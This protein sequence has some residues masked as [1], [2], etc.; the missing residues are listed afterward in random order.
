MRRSALALAV[1]GLAAGCMTGPDYQRPEIALPAAHRSTGAVAPEAVTGSERATGG[2]RAL[3]ALPPPATGGAELLDAAWWS[4]LGDPHLD[5]LIQAALAENK[6]LRAAAARI[7]QF[8]AYLQVSKSAG[9]P[10]AGYRAAR[11][12][13]T[14]SE[15]RQ[16]PLVVGADPVANN[17]EFSF[18]ASWELD[19]W[20]KLRRADEAAYANLVASEEARRA[21]ALSLVSELTAGYIRLLSLDREL[22]LL[23][24]TILS[25]RASLKLAEDRFA[26]GGSGELPVVQAQI[27]LQERES[28]VPEKLAQIAALENRLSQLAGRNPGP[29]ARAGNL[30]EL[31]P[32]K[33]PAGLPADVLVQRPDVRRAE[34]E[35][36]AANAKIG[37]AKAQ[38]LPT[39]ALTG[40][41]GQASTQLSTLMLLTSNFGSFGVA[42]L[43]PLFTAGRIEGQV[44]EAEALREQASIAFAASVQTALRE[45]D[46]ALT[47]HARAREQVALRTLQVAT[48]REQQRLALGRFEG[49]LSGYF[50]VLE[51][52]R[53]LN[54]GLQWL[55]Q[56]RREALTTLIAAYKATGGGWALPD[57]VAS[58]PTPPKPTE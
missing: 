9:L 8:A 1:V 56:A 45:V 32:P 5:A 41:T 19:L 3:A 55:N 26:G 53:G 35:L 20:G 27:Q 47:A 14:L 51:A 23:R 44:R 46:D 25:L 38:Y 30:A 57:V 16:V 52:E 2:A 58:R 28:E 49:G 31:A 54:A 11:T 12:R 36:I 15:N 39:I 17:Y 40:S 22:A 37:V 4:A 42:L 13:D 24:E 18:V 29:I 33:I 21:F 43:G 34:Q 10:Q 6:D 50:E 48:L 7:E